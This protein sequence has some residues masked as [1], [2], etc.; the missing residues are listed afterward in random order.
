MQESKWVS[1][2]EMLERTV[3]FNK[4][5]K[6]EKS[7][8]PLMYN[9]NNLYLD[10]KET[11]NLLIG[12]TGSGKTQAIILPMLKLSILAGESI[13]INDPKGEI[14]EKTANRLKEENY[15]VIAIDFDDARYGNNWNP[16]SIAHTLYYDNNKDKALELIEDIGYYLFT[17][18]NEE[19]DPFWTNS[20]I[21]YFTGLALY[22]LEKNDK[23]DK[24]T[25]E[26]VGKL[27]ND[28]NQNGKSEEFLNSIDKTSVVFMK[29]A[30]T[31]KA[32]PET[33]GSIIA[34]FNQQIEKY[35]SKENLK[36]ML[37]H[38]DFDFSTMFNKKIAVFIIS[39]INHHSK[40]LI[41][42]FINQIINIEAIY[43]TH[44]KRINVLLDEFDSLLPIKDFALKLNY[45]RSLN[46]RITVTIQ[47]YIHLSN[48]YSK[49]D[50]E[51]LKMCF[52]NIMYLLSEDIYTL[53]EI[54]KACG[55]ANK[56]PI[57]SVPELKTI[58]PFEA[59]V[60]MSRS[61]PFKTKLLP[62]YKIDWGI[63]LKNSRIPLR[64]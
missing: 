10:T 58:K 20:T 13:I 64:K 22:L 25:I 45:C 3:K 43:G 18:N 19:K 2:A 53:E 56:K 1:R 4:D 60:L 38:N 8:L 11:H 50:V 42:L 59:I 34:V 36:D 49:Q 32:P 63:D 12:S 16:L 47:S 14:Y 6:I 57:I 15:E 54:S 24:I 23:A 48:M 62:D 7:G 51:I 17:E 40:S 27:A 61:M 9:G 52:G 46:I 55:T 41:P 37:C 28:L 44:E 30:G 35:L 31:L 29:L 21:N 39:G 5:S 33:R 26:E